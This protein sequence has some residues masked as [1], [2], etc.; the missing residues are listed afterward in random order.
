MRYLARSFCNVKT[1]LE[2]QEVSKS[3]VMSTLES[4]VSFSNRK[5]E[6]IRRI[7]TAG[8]EHHRHIGQE[9]KDVVEPGQT[10]D[11]GVDKGVVL[12]SQ[13]HPDRKACRMRRRSHKFKA[14]ERLHGAFAGQIKVQHGT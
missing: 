13:H 14:P 12:R 10:F 4:L 8:A 3:I 11:Q 5:L 1:V 2:R 7:V 9:W 6:H